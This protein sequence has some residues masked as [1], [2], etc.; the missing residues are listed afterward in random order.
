MTSDSKLFENQ[1]QLKLFIRDIEDGL[2]DLAKYYGVDKRFDGSFTVESKQT[3]HLQY[4]NFNNKLSI[5]RLTT[6]RFK[7]NG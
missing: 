3:N 2:C 1:A 5:K 7:T 4:S 6:T